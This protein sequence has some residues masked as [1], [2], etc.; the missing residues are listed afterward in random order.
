MALYVL[1]QYV[2]EFIGCARINEPL[3]ILMTS[4][5]YF[6]G[7]DYFVSQNVCLNLLYLHVLIVK[8]WT[9]SMQY[10]IMKNK[11]LPKL[12]LS[13]YETGQA[14]KKI[15]EDLNGSVSYP[16]VKRCCKMI[17]ETGVI[18]LSKLSACYRTVCTKA[19]I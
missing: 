7:L 12:I 1:S 3:N 2:A 17:G 13:K 14:L 5:L 8:Y 11:D 10:R 16:T 9:N 15:F 6:I 19:A 4:L 18:N